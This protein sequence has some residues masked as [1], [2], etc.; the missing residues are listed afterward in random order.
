M[1]TSPLPAALQPIE[2]TAVT[3]AIDGDGSFDVLMRTVKDHLQQEFNQNRIRGPEFAQVYLGALQTVL[4]SSMQFA[5]QRQA[6]NQ[7]ALVKEKQLAMM[8]LQTEA[9]VLQNNIAEQQ[10]LNLE[11]EGEN[12]VVQKA[13]LQAQANIATQ[14]KLNLEDEL[15]TSVA[16]RA[17]LTQETANLAA[18]ETLIGNQAAQVAQQTTNLAAQKLQ[19]DAETALTV[20]K[21]EN[22]VVEEDVLVAQKCKLQAEF[23]V[24]MLTKSKTTS[25]TELLEQKILTEKAQVTELGVDDNSVVGRQKQLYVAQTNGFNRDA[26]Q[27]AAKV[28]VD[29]WNVRRTTDEGTSA[30]TT[31]KLDD[32]NVGRAVTALLNGIGA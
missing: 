17:K 15:I 6:A 2:I 22:A 20:Q 8:D 4:T 5:L 19:I 1:A 29:S 31:N 28:L 30:N 9:L 11:K 27:K 12:L 18:T 32:T 23:D 10:L 24:L 21:T 7:D 14:Q 13:L 3:T 25:E 26:E 16:Q